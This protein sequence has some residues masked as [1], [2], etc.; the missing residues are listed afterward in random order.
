VTAWQVPYTPRASGDEQRDRQWTGAGGAFSALARLCTRFRPRNADQQL[1]A[2]LNS[3]GF[4]RRPAPGTHR[5]R[6]LFG[7]LVVGFGQHEPK[8][9]R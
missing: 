4:C 9:V 3:C 1:E 6:A 7:G 8:R 5:I 2:L